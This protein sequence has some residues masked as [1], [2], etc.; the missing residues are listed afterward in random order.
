MYIWSTFLFLQCEQA[1]IQRISYLWNNLGTVWTTDFNLCKQSKLKLICISR[2][3]Y[4]RSLKKEKY[5]E[6]ILCVFWKH[7]RFFLNSESLT[8]PLLHLLI[9]DDN[10]WLLLFLPSPWR[11]T[12][13]STQQNLW[14]TA[15]DDPPPS[16]HN[17]PMRLQS[18]DE[19]SAS[20]LSFLT[21]V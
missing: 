18:G 20:S 17:R 8:G 15:P 9:Y 10:T 3:A 1:S 14:V 7:D 16:H 11:P 2:S 19:P 13:C 6:V 5:V 4:I 12:C 21:T